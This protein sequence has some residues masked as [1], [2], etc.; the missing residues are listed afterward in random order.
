LLNICWVDST[1]GSS[2]LA[3][4]LNAYLITVV[5]SKKMKLLEWG[6]LISLDIWQFASDWLKKTA[7]LQ[8][9]DFYKKNY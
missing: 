1:L 9:I 6:A 7:V 2:D 3:V 8:N 4:R 5:P